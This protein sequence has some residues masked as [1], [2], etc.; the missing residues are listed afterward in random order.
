MIKKNICDRSW[1]EIDLSAFRKN[2]SI[3][4]SYLEPHQQFMMI[5]KADAYGHGAIEI[6]KIA[7]EEGA[8]YFGVANP[9]E[10]R[11]LRLQGC[12]SPILILSPCLTSEINVILD[13]D[14]A[15]NVTSLNFA[16][17]LNKAAVVKD[18]QAI[19][20]LK[21]DTGMHRSGILD[22]EF[23]D[24]FSQIQKLSN[25][26]IEGVF[27]HFAS[28]DDDIEFSNQQ[29]ERFWKVIG[30]LPERPKYIH[31]DNSH[32]LINKLGKRSNLVRLGIMAYGIQIPLQ[33]DLGLQPVMTFKT[34]LSQIKHIS[35]GESIGYNRSWIADK[36]CV[37]GILPIGYADG[38]DFMLSNNGVVWLD[39][40]LCKVIG[41]ISMDMICIDLS[42][43]DKPKIGDVATLLGGSRLETR[44]EN[45]VAKYGGNSYELLCQV[46]RRAKSY[47]FQN[48]KLIHSIPLLRRDFVPDDFPD[49]KLNKIIESAIAQRLQSI[50]IGEIIYREMLRD[51]FYYKDRDIHYRHNFHHKIVFSSS[52]IAGYYNAS[53]ILNFDKVLSNDYF[54][55]VCASS[56]EVLRRYF[57]NGDVEYRWLM[58]DSFKLDNESFI[59]CLVQVDELIL[60][61]S[62]KHINDCLEIKCSHPKLR[63]KIGK[64]V[65]FTI[66]TQTLYPTSAHQFS[67]F[68]TE[69]TRGV[70]I[71]FQYP[72]EI[73]EVD[74]V[75]FFSGQD[76]DPLIT[77]NNRE[78]RVSTELNEWIFPISGVVFAY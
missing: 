74:C 23:S 43:I 33:E 58:D 63:G 12:K 30:Q 62:I 76:K 42:D 17:A 5:V 71:T 16:K 49:S 70:D 34:T 57:K 38:Y 47:F 1:V 24:F 60:E 66:N 27:S 9:E 7:S 15:V 2:L 48:G 67:V 18:K 3:L 69:L 11:L 73:K 75:P 26:N 54:L 14:L 45:L 31:I 68:I 6:S 56:D 78:I 22:S 28:A 59:V 52:L 44:A 29:E 25:L 20:H 21:V 64:K 39:N 55:V 72:Q 4:K 8:V 61:T 46:G 37:Y 19:I 35:K 65:H 50:E 53:T 77:Q 10:G 41:R 51:F 40:V 13:N 32:A 36:D